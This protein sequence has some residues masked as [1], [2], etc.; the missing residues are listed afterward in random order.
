V[1][2]W[3]IGQVAATSVAPKGAREVGE[4]ALAIGGVGT[5]SGGEVNAAQSAL[6]KLTKWI[7]GDVIAL[8]VAAVTAFARTYKERRRA[9][10][11][12]WDL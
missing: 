12:V 1:S 4:V 2:A 10:A 7:P 5:G 9:V 6:D 8:Y 11:S 3:Q